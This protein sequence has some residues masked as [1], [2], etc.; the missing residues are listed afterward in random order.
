MRQSVMGQTV[1]NGSSGVG[2]AFRTVV[3]KEVHADK[4]ICMASD[5]QTN[6]SF[7]L[8]LNK[9]GTSSVWPQVGDGWLIDRS[10]GH[11]A[12][13]CKITDNAPPSFTGS[14]NSMDSDLFRLVGLLSGMGIIEDDTSTGTLPVVGGSRNNMSTT[15][16]ALIDILAAKNLVDDQTTAATFPLQTWTYPSY[17]ASGFTQWTATTVPRYMLCPDNTVLVEGRLTA[18]VSA[19]TNGVTLFN[20]DPLLVVPNV[21][22]FPTQTA[23]GVAGLLVLGTAGDVRLW[24]WGATTPTKVIL[25][26]HFSLQA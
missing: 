15:T 6:E 5:I 2:F 24:D 20:I 9:R 11:W 13:R 26:M 1:A 18:P 22:Y 3:I 4:N 19:P 25:D 8:G 10:M 7:Q 21:K 17:A 16:A 14:W 23:V 12:L